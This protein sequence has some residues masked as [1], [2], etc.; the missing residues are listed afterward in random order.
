MTEHDGHSVRLVSRGGSGPNH[1]AIERV[2]A[3]VPTDRP[4]SLREVSARMARIAGVPDPGVQV[5]PRVAVRLGGLAVPFLRE[6]PR[7]RYQFAAPVVIDS[8]AAQN[9]FG[10]TRTPLG[11]GIATTVAWWRANVRAAACVPG[12]HGYR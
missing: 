11:D 12:R 9:T 5:L 2:A 8:S 7:V 1:P 10:V 4:A 6:L 3:D